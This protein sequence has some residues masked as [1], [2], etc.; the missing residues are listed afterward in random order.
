M[1]YLLSGHIGGNQTCR[2]EACNP[3]R[4]SIQSANVPLALFKSLSAALTCCSGPRRNAMSSSKAQHMLLT[5]SRCR[6][7]D[8]CSQTVRVSASD[9]LDFVYSFSLVGT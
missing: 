7:P 9:S 3:Y 2:Q 5:T 4:L 6:K 1:A 8:H